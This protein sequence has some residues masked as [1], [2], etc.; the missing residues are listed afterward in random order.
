MMD[1]DRPTGG[2]PGD[3]APTEAHVRGLRGP[4]DRDQLIDRILELREIHDA[5][6]QVFDPAAVYGQRHLR[7]AVEKALR[8]HAQD[9]AI[10]RDLAT[11]IACYAAG[12][13]QISRALET[14][15]V[16]ANGDV[17]VA[18]GVGE[19][20][21]AALAELQADGFEPAEE[22][23]GMP[24]SALDRLGIPPAMR[25]AVPEAKWELLVVEHVALLD[26]RR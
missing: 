20:G 14:V 6:V 8:S 4:Y 3:Q 21:E 24:S 18:V 10:A 19:P 11:E 12:T 22:L 7:A 5:V 25:Q 15:G 23:P 9:R 17:L 2:T 1:H 13:D 26:A 16:P